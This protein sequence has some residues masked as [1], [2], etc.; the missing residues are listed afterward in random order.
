M[1]RTLRFAAALVAS[2]LAAAPAAAQT[3]DLG[4]AVSNYNPNADRT[5]ANRYDWDWHWGP[6]PLQAATMTVGGQEYFQVQV[7]N[8]AAAELAAGTAVSVVFTLPQGMAYFAVSTGW[9]CAPAAFN[10]RTV[11][12]THALAAP[13][14]AKKEFQRFFLSVTIEATIANYD[15]ICATVSGG[16]QDV[17]AANDKGCTSFF[18]YFAGRPNLWGAIESDSAEPYRN[19]QKRAFVMKSGNEHGDPLRKGMRIRAVTGPLPASFTNLAP[20]TSADPAQWT[21]AVSSAAG[22]KVV[23][24]EKTLARDI[25]HGEGLGS[26][27]VAADIV[28][29]G[30]G[31]PFLN[32]SFEAVDA[33]GVPVL[34]Q[35][36]ARFEAQ[37]TA[38]LIYAN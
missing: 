26:I 10:P 29:T 38:I 4:V 34:L 11:T 6:V 32:A 18:R 15:T 8:D 1:I 27:T 30:A 19:G 12:C 28:A 35:R 20:P 13:A 3:G 24:C 5:N 17:N 36:G 22:G 25:M 9:T 21:C 23:T 37:P 16:G 2:T 31:Q 14:A 33:R 7:N